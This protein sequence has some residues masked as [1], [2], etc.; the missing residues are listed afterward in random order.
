MI[1]K[2]SF[3]AQIRLCER[4]MYAV[5]YSVVKNDADAADVVGEAILRAYEKLGT[6]REESAFKPWLLR[7]VHNCAVE[8]IRKSSKAVAI[9]DIEIAGEGH[10]E[11]VINS[12]SLRA[13]IDS[14]DAPYREMIVLYYYE[15]FTIPQAAR[16]VGISVPAAKQR[17]ARARAKLKGAL[18]DE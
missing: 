6:L 9:D 17:L 14:L 15:R 13:A 16:I 11:R 4:S 2:E 5:A 18:S 7:I 12:V 3:C 10:E 1:D 8:L